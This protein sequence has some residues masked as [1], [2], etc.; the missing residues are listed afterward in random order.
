MSRDAV[1]LDDVQGL[2]R[3]GHGPLPEAV[4]V[5]VRVKS[6][7]AARSWLRSAP[8]TTAAT[9]PSPPATALQIAFTA[10]GVEALGVPASVRAAFSSEFR[11]GMADANRARRLGDVAWNA[12]AQWDWGY[13]TT[14]PH[15]L[16]ML[17]AK[18]GQLGALVDRTC[19]DAWRQAFDEVR[20]LGT[21]D[22]DAVEP[23]GF[24]D[25]VS[26]P[27]VD[28]E[29][30]RDPSSSRHHYSN[31]VALGEFLLGYRNEYGKYTDRPLVDAEA[32][33]AGLPDA[34]DAPDKKDVGRN[35][36]YLVLRQLRQDVRGFWQHVTRE[37]GG[38]EKAADA[39]AARLVGR[40][41][42]GD[43]LS[44]ERRAIAG[45]LGDPE[46]RR[47]NEFTFDNDRAGAVCPVGAHIRRANP[48]NGDYVDHPT[49][50]A[51]LF[52]DLGLP[53][54]AFQDDLVSAV[55]FHRIL[56]RGREY[57]PS[58]T[59]AEALQPA[60][61]DDAERGLHFVCLNANISRQFEFIQGAWLMSST[62]AGLTGEGDPLLGHRQEI[63]GAG[64]TDAFTIQRDGLRKRVSGLPP[65]VTVRGGA[66]FFLPGVRALR[67][68]AGPSI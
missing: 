20:R 38:D 50:V 43:P 18:P 26:Q 31:E 1:D 33:S 47:R 15:V 13:E 25:G 48:R 39:L 2:V 45:V 34:E 19:G 67:F 66:Y 58:L 44:H 65:F 14:V 5:L 4:F 53:G 52:A 23:F 16:V 59:V 54:S 29:Q 49:G 40:T 42:A 55:R 3:F 17:F 63:A 41:R 57:G 7:E 32:S 36:S 60:P 9:R 8:V 27:T 37:A 11:E 30:R 10:Q 21:S 51:R 28:W 24:R 62:F 35:G 6:A 68:L 22:L 56:R 61:T 64:G 12:P 46:E